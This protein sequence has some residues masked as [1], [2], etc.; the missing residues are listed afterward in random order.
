MNKELLIYIG[1]QLSQIRLYPLFD[2]CHYLLIAIQVR[3]DIQQCQTATQNFTRRH[4][5]SCW[6]STVLLCFSGS[7]LTNFLLAESPLKDFIHHQHLL[8]ATVCWYTVF[9]FPFDFINYLLRFLPIRLVIGIG[10]E[11]RRTK[12]I[13]DGVRLTLSLYPDSYIIVILIGAIRGCGETIMS[14]IDRLIRG[15]WLPAQHEFLFPSFATKAC[16]LSSLIFLLYRIELLRFQH[17][18]IYLCVASIFIYVRIITSFFKQYDPFMPFEN[19]SSGLLFNSWIDI[20]SDAYRRA[21]INN[22][23]TT[24]QNLAISSGGLSPSNT[25]NALMNT[26]KDGFTESTGLVWVLISTVLVWIMIPGSG[27]YSSGMIKRKNALLLLWLSPMS[28]SVTTIR[29]GSAFIGD[30]ARITLKNIINESPINKTTIPTIAYCLFPLMFVSQWIRSQNGWARSLGSL[31]HADG[32]PIHIQVGTS[33]LA[34]SLLFGKRHATT[35]NT[36]KH[37]S[38]KYKFSLA[39][40]CMGSIA[41]LVCITPGSGYASI[42]ASVVL[43][44]FGST[45]VYFGRKITTYSSN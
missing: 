25:S 34:Y 43:G 16:F 12:T 7:I 29:S 10:K 18:L 19:L 37:S 26:K 27:L 31:D 41:G 9:Y 2:I 33:S 21:T 14:S 42:P 22:S 24:P 30:L 40:F 8:L 32:A 13:Y 38:P 5:L 28:V 4:P 1:S 20:I 17:E 45:C 36:S 15:V 6:L 23:L 44:T 11:I 39:R 3:D 35:N